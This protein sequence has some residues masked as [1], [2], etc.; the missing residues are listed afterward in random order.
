VCQVVDSA[1]DTQVLIRLRTV[2][3]V[4]ALAHHI[5]LRRPMTWRQSVLDAIE[6]YTKR[7]DST[8]FNRQKFLDDELD[9]IVHDTEFFENKAPSQT[10]SKVLQELDENDW[11]VI[12]GINKLSPQPGL[13]IPTLLAPNPQIFTLFRRLGY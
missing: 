5:F 13:V 10:V 8:V 3:R 2:V 9:R 11:D 1:I 7:H 6:R 4:H 12:W